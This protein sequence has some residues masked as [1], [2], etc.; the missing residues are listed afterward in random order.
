MSANVQQR[1]NRVP[2][3]YSRAL[4]FE[5]F[6]AMC[7]AAEEKRGPL[8]VHVQFRTK[9]EVLCGLVLD[10]IPAK[11]GQTVD[12]FHLESDIGVQWAAHTRVRA[13][14]GLDGRCAC[15]QAD[16]R[17]GDGRAAAGALPLGAPLGNTGVEA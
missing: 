2:A 14:S 9:G 12:F 5:Q 13:C 17:V 10:A 1:G 3:D 11:G 8:P 6:A 7:A 4:T 15:E 16:G